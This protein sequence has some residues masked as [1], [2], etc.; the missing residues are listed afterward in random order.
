MFLVEALL[1]ALGLSVDSLAVSL[2]GGTVMRSCRWSQ[3]F[4]IASVMAVFQ[5]GMVWIGF[6]CGARFEHYIKTFDHWIAF[7]L[8]ASLGGRMIYEDLTA[9][10]RTVTFNLLN[11]KT[12]FSMALATS[13]DALAAGISIALL[14]APVEWQAAVVGLGTF[15]AS[16]AGVYAGH[17]FGKRI[18]LR[19]YLIGGIILTG[20]GL[21]ILLEHLYTNC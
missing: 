9:K 15:L 14:G 7:G 13:I 18:N 21:K 3:V 17:H 12:L 8:L 10:D 2:A 20:I 5:G 16:S 11:S 1:I 19:L 4:R 6:F